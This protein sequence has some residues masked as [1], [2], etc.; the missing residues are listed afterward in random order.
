LSEQQTAPATPWW[1][2]KK[3]ILRIVVP[4][5]LVVIIFIVFIAAAYAFHWSWTGLPGSSKTATVTEVTL[6]SNAKKVTITV[7]DQPGKTL[8]DWLVLLI[9]LLGALAIPVVVGL[10]AAYLSKRQSDISEKNRQ[11]QHNTDLQVTEIQQQEELLRTY[12]DKISELLLHEELST[13]LS[14]EPEP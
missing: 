14:S 12:F 3:V 10:G 1:K 4:A 2:D 13:N 6:P 8:W 5:V 7:E 9:Q 11:Q